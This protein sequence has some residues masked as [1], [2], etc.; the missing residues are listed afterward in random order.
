M[1]PQSVEPGSAEEDGSEG[2]Q[3]DPERSGQGPGHAGGRVPDEGGQR[4]DRAGHGLGERDAVQELRRRQPPVL[5]DRVRLEQRDENVPTAEED[6]AHPQVGC[7]H[8]RDGAE[9]CTAEPEGEQ[10]HGGPAPGPT[11]AEP[12][13]ERA[14][15]QHHADDRLAGSQAHAD[16]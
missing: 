9:P 8:G 13:R 7:E 4:R 10:E 11:A 14:A 2:R 5:A 1:P 12:P 6:A 16:P 15:G 3:V